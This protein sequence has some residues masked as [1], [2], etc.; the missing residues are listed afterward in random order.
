MSRN[1]V[2]NGTINCEA[3]E[4]GM[5][6]AA[7]AKHIRLSRAEPGCTEF[8]ISQSTDDRCTFLFSER[9]ENRAAFEAHTTRTRASAWWGTT[10]HMPRDRVIKTS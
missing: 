3:A 2:V 5:F 9:F 7:A 10:K 4:I 1:V 6:L 8:E